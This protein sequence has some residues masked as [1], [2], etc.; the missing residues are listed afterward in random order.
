MNRRTL[1]N[2]VSRVKSS[3]RQNRET[4][5]IRSRVE[6]L[7]L[8]LGVAG[9]LLCSLVLGY[10]TYVALPTV[11]PDWAGD[12]SRLSAVIVAEV[13][14]LLIVTLV[15]AM[16]GIAGTR[17]RLRIGG[18]HT[19]EV[20]ST[21]A[22]WAGAYVAAFAMYALLPIA[23]P[24]FP[25]LSELTSF[26]LAIGTDMGR[27]DGADAATAI[28][29][30]TRACI[31]APVAEELLFRGAL[32]GWI[33]SHLPAW[34]TIGLTAIGFA[35]I[36]GTMTMT[37]VPLAFLVGIAA[38]YVRERTGSVTPAIIVHII[39][40]IVIVGAGVWLLL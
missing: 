27:L 18:V 19:D 38:G 13:Y 26:L 17:D 9:W 11:V 23:Y 36:H 5:E 31:L 21:I 4:E 14:F 12:I 2:S 22:L 10:A 33:R 35:G 3:V 25:T 29:V 30:L 39:Q 8:V 37:M 32:F 6:G 20:S 7:H 34:P 15:I 28:F 24:A 1:W 16:G 40:N